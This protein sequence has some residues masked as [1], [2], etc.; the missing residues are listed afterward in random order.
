MV[1]KTSDSGWWRCALVT[2]ASH[3]L[4]FRPPSYRSI[5]QH[6]LLC[7]AFICSPETSSPR[8][9]PHGQILLRGSRGG[10]VDGVERLRRNL[11]LSRAQAGRSRGGVLSDPGV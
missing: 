3:L 6:L 11:D 2:V 7:D 5:N 8:N 4:S 1:R 10:G 9:H